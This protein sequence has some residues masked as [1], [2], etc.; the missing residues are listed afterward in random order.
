ME[1]VPEAAAFYHHQHTLS[2]AWAAVASQAEPHARRETRLYR[3]ETGRG[4][5]LVLSRTTNVIG[6]CT[7]V[8]SSAAAIAVN[9]RRQASRPI[10]RIGCAIVVRPG[11]DRAPSGHPFHPAD[12]RPTR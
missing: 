3:R 10:T 1:T 12:D 11:Q 4:G 9:K 8:G 7:V 2:M 5:A 6:Y